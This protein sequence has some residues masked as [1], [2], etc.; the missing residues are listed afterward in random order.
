MG[1]GRGTYTTSYGYNIAGK[2][3]SVSMPRDGVTKSRTFSYDTATQSRLL[4]ATNPENGTVTYVYNND[5]TV[6][7]KTDA[8]GDRAEF[9]YDSYARVAQ[10][11]RVTAATS[12]E[13]RCQ[14]V[15]YTYDEYGGYNTGRL[16]RVRWN[17][18]VN[19]QS[20]TVACA[21]PG[22]GVIGF[23]E[24]YSYNAAGRVST[25]T[26]GIRGLPGRK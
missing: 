23:D 11:R 2:L 21:A 26:W 19:G 14:R 17:W 15:D 9:T 10:T 7:S 24:T 5:G 8:K 6:Q 1:T 20:Q 3:I 12:V 22:G 25:K 4:S 16:T 18:T 13:D